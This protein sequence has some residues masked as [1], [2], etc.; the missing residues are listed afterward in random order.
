[1]KII[2]PIAIDD[3]NFTSSTVP[4]GTS[5]AYN[6]G[7]TYALGDRAAIVSG[8]THT[9]YESLQGSNTGNAPASSPAWWVSVGDTYATYSGAATYALDDRVIDLVGH[10]EYKSLQGSNTGNALTDGA[11]WSDQGFNNRWQ[12]FD[13]SITTQTEQPVEIEVVFTGIN[14]NNSFALLNIEADNIRVVMTDSVDGDVY[15]SGV[16]SMLAN[17]GDIGW[18]S[19]FF[20]PV[21]FLNDFAVIDDTGMPPYIDTTITV[22]LTR[23]GGV[24]KCGAVVVGLTRA[25]GA[26]QYGADVGIKDFS[27]KT[28][29]DN[30]NWT[31]NERSFSK[32][33]DAVLFADNSQIDELQRLQITYRAVPVLWVGSE[34]YT[35]TMVYGFYKKFKVVISGP[36]H[37]WVTMQI[38]GL[39]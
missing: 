2:R 30:G 11:W 28:Q 24:A 19:Y 17:D 27:T 25:I 7:T 31:V 20:D 23:S 16:V 12:M 39:T 9:I 4:E 6:A 13:T 33:M 29:D 34:Q 37:S 35:S 22:T 32:R 14:R 5:P 3:N 38:E 8:Y 21:A 1:M 26:T 15:D 36:M 18:W 10:H